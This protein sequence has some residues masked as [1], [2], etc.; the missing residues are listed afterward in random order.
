MDDSF[1]ISPDAQQGR[2][3]FS[4]DI[5]FSFCD[6]QCIFFNAKPIFH[7]LQQWVDKMIVW[8]SWLEDYCRW[9]NCVQLS[10]KSS[11]VWISENH[12]YVWHIIWCF[13]WN[14]IQESFQT[15][16]FTVDRFPEWG[17]YVR[18]FSASI[19]IEEMFF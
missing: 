9:W 10:S 12:T 15:S 4:V 2:T 7:H 18:V 8:H 6:I 19:Y 5:E 1:H 3:S 14:P 16:S 13:Y 11:E 17:W